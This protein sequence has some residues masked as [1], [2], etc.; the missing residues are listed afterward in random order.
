MNPRT[1]EQRNDEI[2]QTPDGESSDQSNLDIRTI[3]D[4]KRDPREW[5]ECAVRFDRFNAERATV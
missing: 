5:K 4:S 3:G 1:L 2:D